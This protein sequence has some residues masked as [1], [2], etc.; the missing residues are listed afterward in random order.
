MK[1]HLIHNGRDVSFQVWKGLGN[2]DSSN[3]EWEEES[4]V[5]N[6]HQFQELNSRMDIQGMVAN[7][8]QQVDELVSLEKKAM[9]VVEEAFGV[10]MDYIIVVMKAIIMMVKELP[11]LIMKANNLWEKCHLRMEQ[12]NI[13]LIQWPW[14]MQ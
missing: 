11:H 8:F 2:R 4:K 14:R 3:E 5:P 9:D 1:D 7:A 6:K 12:N 13:I 10:L